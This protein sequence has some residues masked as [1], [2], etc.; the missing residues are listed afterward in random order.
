MKKLNRSDSDKVA[1]AIKGL[2]G[3]L[4]GGGGGGGGH[5]GGGGGHTPKPKASAA[6]AH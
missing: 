5:G 1:D 3:K 2:E 6:P 4:G